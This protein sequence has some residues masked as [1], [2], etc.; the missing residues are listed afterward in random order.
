[1]YLTGQP[2]S[3]L[4]C[5]NSALLANELYIV[6][7][8][9]IQSDQ[10]MS[11]NSSS[12]NTIRTIVQQERKKMVIKTCILRM[13]RNGKE[14]DNSAQGGISINIDVNT[15]ALAERATAEHGGEECNSL[16]QTQDLN[17]WV[18]KLTI[19]GLSK[20]KLKKLPIN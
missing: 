3:S 5:L 15:G 7:E 14:V 19:G 10:F 13:G 18:L 17:S 4:D 20:N 9:I 11:I 2:I 12:V 6:E 1:M 16:I 8:N